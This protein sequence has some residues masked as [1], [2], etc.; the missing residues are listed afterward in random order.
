MLFTVTNRQQ[1]NETKKKKRKKEDIEDG[2]RIDRKEKSLL[3]ELFEKKYT[4]RK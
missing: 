3:D 4:S 1:L 2:V